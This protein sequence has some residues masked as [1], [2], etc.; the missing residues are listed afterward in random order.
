[1]S[2]A[3]DTQAKLIT[4]SAGAAPTRGQKIKAHYRKWWWAHIIGFL[5]FALVLI[6]VVYVS[7]PQLADV[8]TDGTAYTESSRRSH[9]GSS[10][11]PR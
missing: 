11:R 3:S 8:G 6:I 10:I 7:P 4:N 9:S 5:L 1:M 2:T